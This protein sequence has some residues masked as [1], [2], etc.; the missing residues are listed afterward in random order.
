MNLLLALKKR[1]LGHIKKGFIE[2]VKN[3]Q[4]VVESIKIN[5]KVPFKALNQC[6]PG[7]R[8][9]LLPPKK[10]TLIKKIIYLS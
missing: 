10:C 6:L 9:V 1:T 8:T 2:L 3:G 5:N 7:L 4:K